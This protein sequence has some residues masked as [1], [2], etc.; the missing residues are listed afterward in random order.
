MLKFINEDWVLPVWDMDF[1]NDWDMD[2]LNE[3]WV[4][5]VWDNI[6]ITT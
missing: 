3:D 6:G 2:F 4:L 5:L 1:L